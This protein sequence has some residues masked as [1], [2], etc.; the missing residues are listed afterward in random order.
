MKAALVPHLRCP[1]DGTPLQ[2]VEPVAEAGGEIVSGQLR[3]AAG[4][5]YAIERGV[6][7]LLD[8]QTFA[9]GQAETRESF[10]VKWRRATN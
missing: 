4:R 8:P 10:S 5:R 2:L 9:P 3:S 6:P 7:V 1:L